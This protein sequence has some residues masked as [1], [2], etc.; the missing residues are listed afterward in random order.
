MVD[1]RDIYGDVQE[2]FVDLIPIPWLPSLPRRRDRPQKEQVVEDLPL[3]TLG[4]KGY[5]KE[6]S[7]LYTI[8][9]V[10]L[11]IIIALKIINKHSAVLSRHCFKNMNNFVIR[12]RNHCCFISII[13]KNNNCK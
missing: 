4:N 12:C 3:L 6:A 9:F 11:S 8:F 5:N 7:V 13:I 2:N 1:V 10:S